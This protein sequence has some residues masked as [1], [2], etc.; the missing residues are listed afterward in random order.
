[1]RFE[2]ISKEQYLTDMLDIGI[3]YEDIKIPKRATMFSAG[4]DIFSVTDF[5]LKPGQTIKLPTGIKFLSDPDKFLLVAPRS[6]HGFK[7]KVQLFNTVGVIDADYYGNVKNDGHI[8]VKLYNDSPDGETLVVR[9]GEA[10]CQ[11]II[12]PYFIVEDDDAFEQR[13]GGFGST[14]GLL[15]L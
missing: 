11:G 12:L 6:G 9:K 13:K 8:W 15:N 2:R 4:Y 7:Y 1:M 3:E 5:E 10:F 14:S